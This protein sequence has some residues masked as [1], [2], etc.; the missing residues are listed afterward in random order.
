MF[1][2][3][4]R[5]LLPMY[6]DVINQ[7]IKQWTAIVEVIDSNAFITYFIKRNCLNYQHTVKIFSFL[8][9]VKWLIQI[10]VLAIKQKVRLLCNVKQRQQY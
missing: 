9:V 4:T 3:F 1:R 5:W 6:Q 10:T 7:M 8:R 2:K